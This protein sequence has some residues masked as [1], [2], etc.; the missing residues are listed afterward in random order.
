MVPTFDP[1][2]SALCRLMLLTRSIF[3]ALT[4]AVLVGTPLSAQRRTDLPSPDSSRAPFLTR[5]P[6][7][8]IRYQT[9]F[10]H[11]A[12]LLQ[13]LRAGDAATLDRLLEDVTLSLSTCTGL[14][15]APPRSPLVFA[16]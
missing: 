15:D 9:A 11:L 1:S 3:S 14:G 10:L 13:A 2:F 12:E 16:R 7:D 8:S 6:A 5:S 4:G